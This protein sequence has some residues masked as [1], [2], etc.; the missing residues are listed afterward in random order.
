MK[1]IPILAVIALIALLIAN[2]DS[3]KKA[4]SILWQTIKDTFEGI[5]NTITEYLGYAIDFVEENWPLLLAVLTGPFG[6]FIGFLVKHKEEVINKISDIWGTVSTVVSRILDATI[7]FAT[8]KLTSI[9]TKIAAIFQVFA[10]A[11]GDV[12]NGI[13]DVIIILVGKTVEAFESVFTS[14]VDVGRSIAQGIWTGLSSM[15]NWFRLLL[16]GWVN[17]NIP[18]AVRK[19]LGI[20]SPSKVMM[21]IGENITKGLYIGMGLPGAPGINLPQINVGNGAGISPVNITINAGLGTDPYALG[22]EV[23]NALSKY[24]RISV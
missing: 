2:W 15:T 17:A 22:R 9:S 14:M 5:L 13:K 7:S 4:A 1:G 18:L 3:V 12:W 20:A 23:K 21:S 19:I 10:D 8:T 24:G 16:T 6:L 11:I